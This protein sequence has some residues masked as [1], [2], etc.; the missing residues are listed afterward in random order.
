MFSLQSI[1][2]Y[3]GGRCLFDE[4]T[5]AIHPG[6]KVGLTGANG[7]GKT[8]LLLMLMGK[9]SADSGDIKL[10]G[11]P[12]ISWA[13]QE[14]LAS[15]SSAINFVLDG[16]KELRRWQQKLRDAQTTNNDKLISSATDKLDHLQAWS[17]DNRASKLLAGLGF[18]EPLQQ[19]AVASFS[20]GWRMR[21]NLARA[22]MCPSDILLLDEPTNHLDL[23]A[24]IWLERW[25][26]RYTGTLVVIAHDRDFLDN[27]VKRILHIEQAAI[28]SWKGNYSDFE[29]LQAEKLQLEQKNNSRIKTERK[30]LQGFIDRFRAKATKAKQVQSRVKAMEKL[31][32]ASIMHSRSSYRFHFEIPDTAPRPILRLEKAAIGYDGKPWL[33]NI[34]LTIHS[35]DR[36]GL[37]GQ[38][39]AGKSTL[40]KHLAGK[41][42]IL[43]GESWFSPNTVTGFFAQ[44]Q[45]E[46]L[47]IEQSPVEILMANFRQLTSQQAQ[48]YLGRYGF[49]GSRISEPVVN[50]S[51][52]EKARLV[53]AL[54]IKNKP[55]LL[56]LDEPTNH[57]DLDMRE[58]LTLA[59]QEYTGAL[60]VVS[61]D[62]HL[63][64]A[65][66]ESFIL[67]AEHQVTPF[68]GDIEDYRQLL[69]S[70]S[71]AGKMSSAASSEG[72]ADSRK[73]QR[74]QQAAH[75]QK[76]APLR[77][78]IKALEKNIDQQQSFIS[79]LEQ[80]LSDNSLYEEK[81][82]E[83]LKIILQQQSE[84]KTKLEQHEADWLELSDEMESLQALD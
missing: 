73:Q 13:E 10:P 82:R 6:D 29:K 67:V 42:P 5:V 61:H 14:T 36:I 45:L 17:A 22:L 3:R 46:Q 54:V 71:N 32:N 56:I 8:S 51:G 1:S 60:M 68:N 33:K 55:N 77:N 44:H 20:G 76:L 69:Q 84:T 65:T 80:Q 30:R 18:S 26:R 4:A 64:R 48:D 59:L 43:E 72:R 63:L 34:N 25:L 41:L 31:G 66:C 23:D 58:S 35:G 38:N 39:G 78:K 62:R 12:T 74:K 53:L 49:H 16:D 79:D 70:K 28:S 52:G 7:S 75:R 11:K 24:I 21:L 2:L 9:L 47:N 15:E 19:Q 57:L 83:Q 37:L 50:F 81:N 27:V 40:L